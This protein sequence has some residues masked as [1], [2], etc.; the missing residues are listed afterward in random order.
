MR[1]KKINRSNHL[2]AILTDTLP[3]ET[4]L[5]F[6]NEYLFRAVSDD[7]SLNHVP[8]IVKKLLSHD[9]ASRPFTYSIS[10]GL[11]GTRTLGI[12]HPASQ[13][14]LAEFYRDFDG[15]IENLCARSKY[16]LRH[17]SRIGTFY[18]QS[19]FASD[20]NSEVSE[21]ADIDPASFHTQRRWAST[22]FYYREFTQM[23]KF[24]ASQEFIRLEQKSEFLL[25]IDISKCFESI[26]THSLS[27]AV[28]GKEFSK[29][30]I[31]AR[32][33][34]SRFDELMRNANWAETNGILIGPEISRVFAEIIMQ[35][36]DVSVE[37]AV[38][39]EDLDISI[40]RYIDDYF[41][42][43]NSLPEVEKAKS[44]IQ[45]EVR[46]YNLHLNESKTTLTVRPLISKLTVARDEAHQLLGNFFKLMRKALAEGEQLHV[47][48]DIAEKTISEIRRISIRNGV[49]YASLASPALAVIVRNLHRIR[50]RCG[51]ATKLITMSRFLIQET[52]RL[53]DFIFSMDV[54]A[55][56]THKMAKIFYEVGFIAKIYG[57]N[58][59]ALHGQMIDCMRRSLVHAK[60]VN[61]RGPEII[62]LLVAIEAVFGRTKSVK[63][64]DL[65]SALGITG[66]WET[67][68]GKADYFDLISILYLSKRRVDFRRASNAAVRE[69]CH[70][71]AATGRELP[72]RTTETMLF[73]DLISC[74]YV[75]TDL[76]RSVLKKATIELTGNII[77]DTTAREHVRKIG[78]LIR[79]VR[80]DGAR[81]L[82]ALLDRKELQPAYD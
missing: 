71:I 74:P 67:G 22:Y 64:D 54:R 24:F 68:I 53:A 37:A 30:T 27:W 8:D 12:P 75:D 36:I 55:A 60:K 45:N 4:P 41:I 11:S 44:L 50:V 26:Y 77:S 59:G 61:V 14:R 23:Y 52:L 48:K 18:F 15:F 33:F 7:T 16:S 69:I 19:Q 57:V 70:R 35:A 65:A 29:A 72:Y 28:R 9:Q 34:E 78:K 6:T 42:F 21:A 81:N 58:G 10:K 66:N 31:K 20:D 39:K 47:P 73:F 63:V 38:T 82:H 13:L 1:K 46:S 2:R 17:P 25:R 56:T 79:F 62:N 5:F 40:R 32:S 43:G 51:S 76:K 80:W 49:D 3:Y